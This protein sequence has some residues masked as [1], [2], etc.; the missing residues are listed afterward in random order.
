M[1]ETLQVDVVIIGAGASGLQCAKSL[2]SLAAPASPSSPLTNDEEDDN[3]NDTSP[4]HKNSISVL[5]LEA[6]NRVGG[7]VCTVIE[8]KQQ[9]TI[10]KNNDDDESNSNNNDQDSN[11][12]A[13]VEPKEISFARDLGAAWVHGTGGFHNGMPISDTVQVP[14]H[15]NDHDTSSRINPMVRLLQ[16]VKLPPTLTGEVT[17]VDYRN[18]LY[19]IFDGNGWTRPDTILH[20]AERVALFCNGTHIPNNSQLVAEAIH[21]HY[22]IRRKMADLVNSMFQTGKGME[23]VH[24]SVA[25]VRSLLQQA[26]AN[27]NATAA[28]CDDN[29]SLKPSDLVNLLVPFYGFLTENW[30]GLSETDMQINT[31][32]GPDDYDQVQYNDYY[33]HCQTDEVYCNEG[34]YEGPHCKVTPGMVTVLEPLLNRVSS[35]IK[36]DQFV[37]S[38]TKLEDGQNNNSKKVRIQ[39]SSGLVVEAN[40]CVCTIP[41]G[42]LQASEEDLFEEKK[43]SEDNYYQNSNNG[44]LFDPPLG[45]DLKEAMRF[46]SPGAYKKVF[47]TF[48]HIFWPIKEPMLG[49]VRSKSSD[50]GPSSTLNAAMHVHGLGHYLL[51]FN[52]WAKDSIPCLEAILCGNIGKWAINKS[53]QEIQHAVLQFMEDAM[54]VKDIAK[55]CVDCN[56]TKWE[57]D[58]LTRGSYS[59]FRL[60]TLERHIDTFREPHWDGHLVF[61]GEYTE[62]EHMGSVHAALMSGERAAKLASQV[63]PEERWHPA[64]PNTGDITMGISTGM[65]I[66][67]TK[68]YLLSNPQ[69]LTVIQ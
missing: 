68:R 27:A 44:S 24:T 1:S 31:I 65:E 6:R 42:C 25:Q 38:I 2:L 26:N 8:S 67:G 69:Q 60:G 5:I 63:L 36:L 22:Q 35:N 55:S 18:L 40:C 41:I 13:V 52:F 10:R 56:I 29:S 58:P 37:T 14:R 30:S 64:V 39:T 62:S 48:D 20:K 9:V 32:E 11:R 57:E 66:P 33:D 49:L 15:H 7:R 19:P 16:Q 45:P 43:Q 61:A 46:I 28:I 47:L 53:D 54:G 12:D 50:S 23:T 21:T 34:D 59:S 4:F 17:P 3:N 51:V